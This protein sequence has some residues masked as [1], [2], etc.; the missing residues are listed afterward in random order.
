MHLKAGWSP[1]SK[2]G[3]SRN[4]NGSSGGDQQVMIRVVM[5]GWHQ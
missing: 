5:R 3:I 1:I 2:N 4:S